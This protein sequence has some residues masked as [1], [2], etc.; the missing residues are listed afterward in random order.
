[1]LLALALGQV[2]RGT[3]S[4]RVLLSAQGNAVRGEWVTQ[5]LAPSLLSRLLDVP[6]QIPKANSCVNVKREGMSSM[7]RYRRKLLSACKNHASRDLHL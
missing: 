7:F 5:G 1:M 2:S 6:C 3:C 4:P